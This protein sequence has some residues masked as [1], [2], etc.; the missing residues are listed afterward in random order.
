VTDYA[1]D[2]SRR[3]LL[4]TWDTGGGR[5]ADTAAELR[6]TSRHEDVLRLAYALTRLSSHLWRTYTHPASAADSLEMNTEGWRRQPGLPQDDGYMIQSYVSV[7]EAAHRV[8]RALHALGDT[9]LTEHVV[10]DVEAELAAVEHAERG[11]LSGRARQAVLLARAD[12]DRRSRRR[13]TVASSRRRH[14]RR[15]SRV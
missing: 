9:T 12:A 10:A 7:E 5:V 15:A 3:L 11:G 2:E 13:R 1:F 6:Q 8:G 4:R 14:H